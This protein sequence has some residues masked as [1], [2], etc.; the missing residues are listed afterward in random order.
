MGKVY[1]HVHIKSNSNVAPCQQLV[2]RYIA[3]QLDT[4]T[5]TLYGNIISDLHIPFRK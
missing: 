2:S 1:L 5:L 4:R 3:E